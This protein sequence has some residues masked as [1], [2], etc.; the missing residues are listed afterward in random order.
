LELDFEEIVSHSNSNLSFNSKNL[1]NYFN[2][3]SK[4]NCKEEI[5]K[6]LNLLKGKSNMN[7]PQIWLKDE[8]RKKSNVDK[9]GYQ[10]LLKKFLSLHKYLIDQGDHFIFY[11]FI[12]YFFIFFFF[13]VLFF[14]FLFFFF[15]F[16]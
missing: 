5:Q 12:L 1:K 10:S 6:I 4:K 14:F 9:I 11:K 3:E 8:E 2:K 7:I 15:F 16:F 13:F